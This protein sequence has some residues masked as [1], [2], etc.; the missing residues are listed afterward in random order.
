MNANNYEIVI[1]ELY[2]KID[3]LERII[4]RGNGKP[5]LLT[6]INDLQHQINNLDQNVNTRF[7]A[8]L[9]TIN[10]KFAHMNTQL[11]TYNNSIVNVDD[12]IT[13]HIEDTG[14]IN[15]N[16]NN[17]K[18]AIIVAVIACIGSLITSIVTI[19]CGR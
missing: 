7:Q 2:K 6:Q 12:K 5:A 8:L 16:N 14:E 13:Q 19:T 18:T 9:D 17:N 15:V 1:N 10:A 11:T 3:D 4:Y